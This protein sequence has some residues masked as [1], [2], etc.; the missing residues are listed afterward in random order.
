MSKNFRR[1]LGILLAITLASSS[2]PTVLASSDNH[3]NPPEGIQIPKEPDTYEPPQLGTIPLPESKVIH[4]PYNYGPTTVTVNFPDE[5]KVNEPFTISAA[6]KT[7]PPPGGNTTGWPEWNYIFFLM[8]LYMPDGVTSP[9]EWTEE[10]ICP[11]WPPFS[12]TSSGTIE[13]LPSVDWIRGNWY[14]WYGV[15]VAPYQEGNLIVASEQHWPMGHYVWAWDGDT[16]TWTF[17]PFRISQPGEYTFELIPFGA[18]YWGD[19][20]KGSGWYWDAVN[21]FGNLDSISFKIKA[22]EAVVTATVD[23]QPDTL[24]RKN[25]GNSVTVYIEIPGY[26]PSQ[27]SSI[28]L[29]N[30]IPAQTKPTDIGDYD[31]DGIPD[32]M[33][34]FD[35]ASLTDL[36][37]GNAILKVT[38]TINGRQFRGEDTIRV[39]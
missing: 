1:L 27:A 35:R 24:N 28:M 6:F 31:N 30:T 13:P 23:I 4:F 37:L 29:N 26:D 5:V 10:S 9:G 21:G 32:L 33:V 3:S 39:L 19:P 25:K 12:R 15:G 14:S 22:V 2:I 36:P 38:G 17:T 20:S 34:K 16:I 18:H 7:E 11:W 8:Q